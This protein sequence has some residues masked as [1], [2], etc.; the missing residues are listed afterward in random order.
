M[1]GNGPDLRS[2]ITIDTAQ[3]RSVAEYASGKEDRVRLGEIEGR[4]A[5]SAMILFANNEAMVEKGHVFGRKEAHQILEMYFRPDEAAKTKEGKAS[6]EETDKMDLPVQI[7]GELV[8][9]GISE[10]AATFVIRS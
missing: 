1:R 6:R 3:D 10:S 2:T 4:F 7:K 5:G 8:S 9:A